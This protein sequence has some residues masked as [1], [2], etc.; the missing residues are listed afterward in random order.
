MIIQKKKMS[1]FRARQGVRGKEQRQQCG[2]VT[3]DA[4]ITQVLSVR[5]NIILL[6]MRVLQQLHYHTQQIVNTN[7]YVEIKA[8]IRKLLTL[9]HHNSPHYTVNQNTPQHTSHSFTC[10][11]FPKN[12]CPC[13][14]T[15][16]TLEPSNNPYVNQL[17]CC[18]NIVKEK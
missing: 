3:M 15:T 16:K 9:S 17:Y 14:C 12:K 10:C 4:I 2:R 5:A 18:N 8:N 7:I 1:N 6:R 11:T 13:S